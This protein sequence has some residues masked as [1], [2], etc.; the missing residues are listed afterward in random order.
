MT[1]GLTWL[2]NGVNLGAAEQHEI[3]NNITIH[4]EDSA[5]EGVLG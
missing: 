1:Q 2:Y 4:I 3:I 5:A